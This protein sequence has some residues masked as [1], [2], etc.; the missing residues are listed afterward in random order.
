M[1]KGLVIWERVQFMLQCPL[2]KLAAMNLEETKEVGILDTFLLS[3]ST[4]LLCTTPNRKQKA[5]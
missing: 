4:F 5:G 3:S 2:Q 1:E